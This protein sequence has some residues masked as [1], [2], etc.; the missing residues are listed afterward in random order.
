MPADGKTIN[1]RRQ[2][3]MDGQIKKTGKKKKKKK[4]CSQPENKCHLEKKK[5][6]SWQRAEGTLQRKRLCLSRISA[7]SPTPAT[8][9]TRER[10]GDHRNRGYGYGI[11][12][13]G[14]TAEQAQMAYL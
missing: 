10:R 1:K 9:S 4:T 5:K 11:A 7:C 14:S 13:N 8:I 12:E 3:K 2:W 6:K